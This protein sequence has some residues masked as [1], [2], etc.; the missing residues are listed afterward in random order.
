MKKKNIGIA[1]V[2]VPILA[3]GSVA[4]A[5][6]YRNSTDFKP[7]DSNQELQVNQVVFD[8]DE[9]GAGHSKK[10]N[11]NDES[12]LLKK[13]SEADNAESAQLKDQ[14][15]YLFENGQMHTESVGILDET[16][17][18]TTSAEESTEAAQQPENVYS[19]TKD[20]SKADTSLD[21]PAASSNQ[22]GSV[23]G[24][25]S[26]SSGSSS[27]SQ[28]GNK[29][30]T[31]STTKPSQSGNGNSG[32]KE[33]TGNNGNSGNDQ[34][35]GNSG[36]NGNPSTT[37]P[38][39]APVKKPAET[40]KDPAS[41]KNNGMITARPFQDGVKPNND[42]EED[43][44]NSSI[45]IQQSS[46]IDSFAMYEGQTVEKRDIFN[47]LDTMVFGKDE[48][49]YQ[50][51]SEA[52]D[53][54]VRIDAVSFDGGKTW[55]NEFPVTIP[56]DIAKGNMQLK[57][58]YRLSVNDSK[59]QERL[60][61]YIAKKNRI[62]LLSEQLKEENQV[63]NNDQIVNINSQYPDLGAKLNLLTYQKDLW[64]KDT[65]TELF[66]GWTENGEKVS[67]FYIAGKGR[68]ILEPM[69]M[70][71]L[72]PAYTVKIIYQWMSEDYE[73]GL[74][75]NNLCYLQTLTDC[76]DAAVIS[77][78]QNRKLTV[79]QYIQAVIIDENA[80][81]DTDYLEIPDSVLYFKASDTGLIV[82]KGFQV[83]SENL[84]YKTTE[85][86]ILTNKKETEYIGIPYDVKSL[87]VPEMVHRVVITQNNQLSELVLKAEI[88][89]EIPEI[90]YK[91]LKNCNTVINDSLLKTYV[92]QNY[93]NILQG[94]NNTVSAASDP[95]TTYHIENESM[96]SNQG[97]LHY[98]IRTGRSNMVI[99]EDVTTVESGVFNEMSGLTTVTMPKNGQAVTL[100]KDCFAGSEITKIHCYSAEQFYSVTDQLEQSGAPENVSIEL[101]DVSADGISYSASE[102]DGEE[103]ITVIDVPD[104]I[105]SFDGNLTLE[106]ESEIMVTAVG[107]GAFEDCKNLKWVSLP[108]TVNYIGY[109]AFKNCSALEG[110]FISTEDFVYIGNQSVDGC[111]SLRFIAS[112]AMKAELQDGY[113]PVI[114]DSMGNL[115]FYVPT[116]SEGYTESSIYFTAESGVYGYEMVDIGDGHKMLFG[117]NEDWQ[118][119]LGIRSTAEVAD[120]VNLPETTVEIF[121]YA[122]ENT[123]S[124]SGKYEVNWD[125]LTNLYV[126]DPGV[127][128]NSDLGGDITL[129]GSNIWGDDYY[130]GNAVFFG[131]RNI[132]SVNIPQ[133][134][135]SMGDGVFTDCTSLKSVN[136]A[137]GSST[138]TIYTGSF[139]NCDNLTDI[140]FESSVPPTL[141][142]YG[143]SGFR[144]NSRYDWNQ[145]DEAEHI[146]IHVPQG[147][148][149]SYVKAWRYPFCGYVDVSYDETAYMRMWDDIQWDAVW[150]TGEFPSDEDTMKLFDEKLLTEENYLRQMLGIE[151]AQEPTDLYHYRYA[152]DELTLLRA[153]SG[154]ESLDLGFTWDK[155]V[156]LFSAF[157]YIGNK[158]FIKSP[159]LNQLFVPNSVYG[160]YENAFVGIQ[161]E[162]LTIDID[163][164]TPPTLIRDSSDHAFE[165]GIEDSR[166]ILKVP[167]GYEDTYIKEWRYALSGYENLEEVQQAVTEE[168]KA[169]SETGVEPSEAEIADAV[170]WKL[171][172]AENRLR[173]MMGLE[174]LEKPAG[175]TEENKAE[176]FT[177]G[178]E[179]EN[180]ETTEENPEEDSA[181]EME[182][183]IDA[184][185][186]NEEEAAGDE[187]ETVQPDDTQN[188][189]QSDDTQDT[190]QPEE[191]ASTVQN[192]E[193]ADVSVESEEDIQE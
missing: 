175:L 44:S 133:Y 134:G 109:Q 147:E 107:D 130:I 94:E 143:T 93:Q 6:S 157:N 14:A 167:E 123:H 8:G 132:T 19:I 11:G 76:T 180:T 173:A 188:T 88:M 83:S 165:F 73:V 51:G 121:Y 13:N 22:G 125:E 163:S 64:D 151:V 82:R 55:I 111:D 81:V 4:L 74:E 17:K 181:G 146:R 182:I 90:A 135:Y 85:D 159:Q 5:S 71:P 37:K 145:A 1:V 129:S 172:P 179:K 98:I 183:T 117:V 59:W 149:L 120:Q 47:A 9:A 69:D 131:C 96:V 127:F 162:K 91:N 2:S 190:E 89:D 39:P 126:L 67:W 16:N 18:D 35:N 50:W 12:R 42:T 105:T 114:R 113:A 46:D 102:K 77:D 36:N 25:Q 33:N 118:P 97:N 142:I 158:A 10:K 99:P 124:S 138:C 41:V 52:F 174:L 108:E 86:G 95:E 139:A 3:A 45:I 26:S 170:A 66:P 23:G 56:S 84:R 21:N 68:H 168:L 137:G 70:V 148:E 62:F 176:T 80:D 152:K 169:S 92:E 153:P 40:A 140:T 178:E 106:D 177:D 28:S 29:G 116:N 166:I 161:S 48:T 57:V 128:A 171:L 164:T 100:E 104:T 160:I 112:N 155:E 192:A 58:S 189:E 186:D 49:F 156:P 30:N 78:G 72:D 61:P 115:C 31:S 110:L 184:E 24:S 119:W 34:N 150:Q 65:L 79:P 75:Y 38:T 191:E 141:V 154:I 20:A 7:T 193:S 185:T 103:V 43:G 54:Y 63:I 144:F 15:D 53:K 60:V 32:N 101:L 87:T 122:M 136:I 27:G 187:P